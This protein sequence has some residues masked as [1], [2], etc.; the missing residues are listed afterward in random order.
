MLSA[1]NP[2][3]SL[4]QLSS[5]PGATAKLYLDFNGNTEASW[6]S[7][8]NV[9]TPVYDQDGDRTTFSDAELASIQEIWARV[10]EDYAPFNIDVTTIDPGN[11][12]DKVTA[13]I[14]IG[15]NY[16][17]WYGSSAGGVAYIG[18][19]AGYAPNTGFVFED[20]LGNGNARY[21]A[22]A[23]SHEAGHLF[24]LEHQATWNGTQLV[25]GY[26]QG[27]ADWA[28]I[29]GVGY[30]SQRT[31]WHNGATS[32]AWDDYQ[33]DMSLI[34]HTWNGFGYK[35]D[36]YGSTQATASALAATSGNV[37]M[38][39][40]VGTNTDEDWFTFTTSGGDL[41]LSLNVAQVGANLD[42]VLELR[43]A[44]GTVLVTANPT[45]TF[46]ASISTTLASGTYFVVVHSS[47]GYGNVGRYTLAGTAPI[48]STGGGGSGGENTAFPEIDVANGSTAIQ[49]GGS[50]GFGSVQVGN[51]VDR[52]LTI[53]NSGT[54]P[55]TLTSP[56]A[57]DM[58]AGYSIVS[59]L[60]TNTLAA[61]ASTTITIRFTPTAT[62]TTAGSFTLVSDDSN[63]GSF[64]I[65]LTGSATPAPAPEI[66]IT[67]GTVNVLSG[68]SVSFGSVQVGGYI[69][70]VITIKNTG[71][72]PLTLTQ[73]TAG[74][75]PAGYSIVTNLG[76]TTLAAGASTTITIR[77]TPTSAGTTNGAL[78]LLSNDSDEGSFVIN[79][80]GSA[81]PAP[82][83]EITVLNGTTNVL[84]GGTVDFGNVQVSKYLN[85]TITIKNTGNATLTL[86]KPTAGQMPAGFTIVTN[87]AST[88]L[89]AG[90][91]TTLTV[92]YTPTAV[93]ATGGILNLLSNDA[94]EGTFAINLT[95]TG[96]PGPT[97]EITV[98]V[99][100]L[101]VNTG[102]SVDFGDVQV[103]KYVNKVITI[104]NTGTATLTLVKPTAGQMPAGFT[105][106]SNFST[107][108]LTAGSSA[109]I[110]IRFTPTAVGAAGG[111]L[112]L[113]SNDADEGTFAINLNGNGT[114]APVIRA[115]DNGAA[116][117]TTTGTW[118][119][120]TYQ[121]RET[122]M[123]TAAKG[124]G[125]TTATW[126]FTAMPPGQYRVHATWVGSIL[127]ATNAPFTIYD[128]SAA[129]GTVLANQESSAGGFSWSGS[130]WKDLGTFNITGDTTRVT[131]T[132]AA[133]ETVVAD[134]VRIERIGDLPGG[135]PASVFHSALPTLSAPPVTS[136]TPSSSPSAATGSSSIF[137]PFASSL[138]ITASSRSAPSESV[139]EVFAAAADAHA[140][141]LLLDDALALLEST[142]GST[143]EHE[144][145][146]DSAGATDS[147]FSAN[148]L[149]EQF[150]SPQV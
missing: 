115:I 64:V 97:P 75:M 4:P 109:S 40:L 111:V 17:D 15:G 110:T 103:T 93:G 134:A 136:S 123:Q 133:N 41:N 57:G 95:G 35:A 86:V 90:A 31:T 36:D 43:D 26:S 8:S 2:L 70:K 105:I 132:N 140:E 104:K 96:T 51:Y 114:P 98:N 106:V 91:S 146:A 5:N 135:S 83:P 88:S 62:G 128:G 33:D 34:S 10:S 76:S 112:N 60:G 6:G 44:S 81:T 25:A 79:F 52:T 69:N 46:N 129:V 130:N 82:A 89:A 47:G 53:H 145:D 50:V 101:N 16:S 99:G 78:T 56:T 139:D 150:G 58:P 68:G 29:M 108:S 12:T 117:F 28:P 3:S 37:S 14:A 48:G 7:W 24:G 127:N 107:T 1:S 94:D 138:T 30:Y 137:A 124:N 63:E 45:N 22:E 38:A 67:N 118:T 66:T 71:T 142:A 102:D 80:T 55:L 73:P 23:A 49:S 143:T 54:G 65:N 11:N 116:G 32:S 147:L 120:I 149:D 61:G 87:L 59:N 42:S 13:R 121:G 27:T 119:K 113:V 9:I 72:G 131:L 77:F 84:T 20:A 92:R 125:S 85:K 126:T 21:V 100:T 144:E 74:D 39:G 122:D 148:W 19:F 18:G 141:L